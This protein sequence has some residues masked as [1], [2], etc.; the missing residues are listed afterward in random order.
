MENQRF[1]TRVFIVI[2]IIVVVSM[3]LFGCSDNIAEK[4]YYTQGT[5]LQIKD[6]ENHTFDVYEK[7][8]FVDKWKF[9]GDWFYSKNTKS[10]YT[11]QENLFII[12]NDYRKNN[13]TYKA[14]NKEGITYSI[15]FTKLMLPMD[16]VE[17]SFKL[18][19]L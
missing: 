18:I 6:F 4:R 7:E 15:E 2:L 14:S 10:L 16:S 5:N 1:D 13:Y 17:H 19:K 3:L 9:D 12:G 8:K 11:I